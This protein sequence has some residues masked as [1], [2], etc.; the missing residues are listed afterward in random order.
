MNFDPF[1]PMFVQSTTQPTTHY[2]KLTRATNSPVGPPPLQRQTNDPGFYSYSSRSPSPPTYSAFS[3]PKCKQCE[4]EVANRLLLRPS[5]SITLDDLIPPSRCPH[6][7]SDLDEFPKRRYSSRGIVLD[8]LSPQI[9]QVK[10][11]K[12][13][14][15]FEWKGKI[16]TSKRLIDGATITILPQ[17]IDEIDEIVEIVITTNETET[18]QRFL[19]TKIPIG[20]S[21]IYSSETTL[22]LELFQPY[23]YIQNNVLYFTKGSNTI[24]VLTDVKSRFKTMIRN[25]TGR[26]LGKKYRQPKKTMRKKKRKRRKSN[27]RR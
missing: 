19:L 27:R 26:G 24:P 1:D 18:V 7:K 23:M 2:Q 13:K 9:P 20:Q 21:E 12:I 3:Q 5:G 16:F 15:Y 6:K 4:D 8:D 25:T 14:E 22:E 17:I 11:I 10:D